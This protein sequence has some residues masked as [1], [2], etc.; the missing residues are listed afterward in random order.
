MMQL[1]MKTCSTTRRH[2]YRRQCTKCAF[3]HNGDG[4]WYSYR[5][6]ADQ[7]MTCPKCNPDGIDRKPVDLHITRP[8]VARAR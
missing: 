8:Q 6:Q 4:A 7:T 1:Q 2:L 5:W 3:P